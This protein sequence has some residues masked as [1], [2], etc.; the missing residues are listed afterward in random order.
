MEQLFK[1]RTVKQQKIAE[2]L[3]RQGMTAK[4]IAAVRLSGPAMVR[5]TNPAGQY[6]DLY[7]DT[8]NDVRILDVSQEREEELDWLWCEETEDPE[9]QEWRWDL[10]ADED[11][12]VEQWEKQY[13]IGIRNLLERLERQQAVAEPETTPQHNWEPEL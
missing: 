12:M 10:T 9:T 6:M 8:S 11:A 5:I 7:C 2:W 1:C 4:D 13:A 3:S